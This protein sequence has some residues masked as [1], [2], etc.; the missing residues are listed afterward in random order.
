MFAWIMG[1]LLVS[2]PAWAHLAEGTIT[3]TAAEEF[4]GAVPGDVPAA[5][6]GTATLEVQD[7]LTITYDITVHDLTGPVSAGHIHEG[8]PGVAGNIVMA[9]DQSLLGFTKTSDTTFQGTTAAISEDQFQKLLSGAY[10]VNVHTTAHGLGEVRGQITLTA[11]KG[12]CSC[13]ALSRHDFK[14]CVNG[15]IKKLDKTQKKSA[16]VKAL[17]KA[18]AKSSCGLATTP[19][20]KPLACCLPANDVATIVTGELCAPVK[21]D[22]Q[23]TKLGGTVVQGSGCAPTNPCSPPASPSGAFID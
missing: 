10:Y 3:L 20:K 23:C 11:V 12:T 21:K 22:T 17:K 16:E 15:E 14:K 9:T 13:Q 6:G 2:G 5:A 19:K 8:A 7:D 4:P 18:V 1:L